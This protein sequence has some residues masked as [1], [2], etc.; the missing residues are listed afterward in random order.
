[1]G[2]AAFVMKVYR[3]DGPNGRPGTLLDSVMVP[4]AQAT[5][6][7]IVVPLSNPVTITSGG[8]Y[9]LWDMQGEGVAIARDDAAPFSLRSYEVLGNTW[10]EYRDREATDFHLGLRLTRMDMAINEPVASRATLVPNPARDQV[11]IEGLPAGAY[12]LQVSDAA[13]RVVLDTRRTTA[14]GPVTVSVDGLPAG[15]YQVRLDGDGGRFHAALV[16]ER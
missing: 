1:M 5:P 3:D 4:G 13:G 14:Q 7:D 2:S 10:A 9:V 11:R 15:F 6:G 12:R 8:V 16:V